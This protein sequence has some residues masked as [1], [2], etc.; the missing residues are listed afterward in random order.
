MCISVAK[1]VQNSENITKFI[2]F[3]QSFVVN[4]IEMLQLPGDVEGNM[5]SP[6]TYGE[7]RGAVAL[8]RIAHHEQL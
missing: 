1:L 6:C 3:Y 4:I 7:G 2:N 5:D 8:Q